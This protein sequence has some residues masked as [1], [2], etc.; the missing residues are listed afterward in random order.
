MFGACPSEE[1]GLLQSDAAA[2][3]R[4]G[5]KAASKAQQQGVLHSFASFLEYAAKSTQWRKQGT[6]THRLQMKC[7]D[8]C[9][10]DELL[11]TESLAEDWAELLKR[12][13]G[14]P[15]VSLPVINE[16]GDH[17]EPHPWGDAP[18]AEYTPRLRELV[19]DLDGWVF[20]TFNYTADGSSPRGKIETAARGAREAT[21]ASAAAVAAAAK[22]VF[23]A[24]QPGA[25]AV[26]QSP[27]AH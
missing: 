5:D 21:A 26:A 12:H 8:P 15:R 14:L 2:G 22:A 20:A 10:W 18:P 4:I 25:A 11:R 7:G 19:R 16:S 1:A 3:L 6:Q 23:S 24:H 27:G 17:T 13:P 9:A